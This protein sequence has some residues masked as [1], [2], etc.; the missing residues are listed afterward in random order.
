[1][2]CMGRARWQ[3]PQPQLCR[4][5]WVPSGAARGDTGNRGR[6]MHFFSFM[7]RQEE[8]DM[9]QTF[10]QLPAGYVALKIM[11]PKNGLSG[12]C[13]ITARR[14]CTAWLE[15]CFLKGVNKS[16]QMFVQS[17]LRLVLCV[18]WGERGTKEPTGDIGGIAAG[19]SLSCVLS[20][21]CREPRGEEAS[22]KA[23]IG[24]RER[25]SHTEWVQ[26]PPHTPLLTLHP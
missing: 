23:C 24:R 22:N 26:P 5:T 13:I 1:M 18:S 25:V 10:L 9:L 2:L 17:F 12:K 14:R 16:W 7:K 4:D 21:P 20:S 19:F 6:K 8:I 15:R 3:H 11:V